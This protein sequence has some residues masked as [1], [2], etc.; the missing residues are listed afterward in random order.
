MPPT[1][2]P[3]LLVFHL[4]PNTRYN[5]A[6]AV[7]SGLSPFPLSSPAYYVVPNL[8]RKV[9]PDR[10]LAFMPRTCSVNKFNSRKNFSTFYPCLRPLAF[11]LFAPYVNL[12]R[13]LSPN[14]RAIAIA[15]SVSSLTAPRSDGIALY[16]I[17]I[18]SLVSPVL[19]RPAVY[20]RE[21]LCAAAISEDALNN[22]T[23]I[24]ARPPHPPHRCDT[25]LH[26][27]DI[28]IL[29]LRRDTGRS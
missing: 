23:F 5:D 9:Q 27:C 19:E 1:P 10:G 21:V 15:V 12:S 16:Y 24:V 8:R 22:Y 26:V 11:A 29:H 28:R 17:I 3:P 4:I 2:P 7:E 25:F 14:H 20:Y 13:P 6:T 18:F